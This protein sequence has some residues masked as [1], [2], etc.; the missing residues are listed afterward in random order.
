MGNG[1]T[2]IVC[3]RGTTKAA[4]DTPGCQRVHMA[5][6]DYP[7]ANGKTCDRKMCD[8]H[9]KPVGANRDYCPAHAKVE[10]EQNFY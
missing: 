2:A 9:R 1:A 3:T 7:L 10:S 5:L 6:C 8:G 4:C